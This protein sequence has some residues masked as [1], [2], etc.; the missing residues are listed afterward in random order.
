MTK[1]TTRQPSDYMP[2]LRT[3][4]NYNVM[5]VSDETGLRCEDPSLAQQ[6]QKDQADINFILE[7]FGVTGELP[8]SQRMPQYRDFDEIYD[9]HSAMNAVIAAQ[10]SF[11]AL[12]A[13]LR[14]RFD[15][16]P[17]VLIDFLADEKNAKEAH[18]LGLVKTAPKENISSQKDEPKGELAQLPT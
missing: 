15:N 14:A 10:D 18:D 6:N 5:Q 1:L 17:A 4:Y 12:P 16:D 2:F 11:D 7:R 13:K 8:V 9:Y 3:P